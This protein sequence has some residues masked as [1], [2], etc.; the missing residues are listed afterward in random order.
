MVSAPSVP[1]V[2]VAFVMMSLANVLTASGAV[3]ESLSKFLK[4][5]PKKLFDAI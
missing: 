5:S 3:S 1:S 2:I 4:I